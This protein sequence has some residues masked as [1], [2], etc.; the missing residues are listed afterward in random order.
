[1]S[2]DNTVNAVRIGRKESNA[3]ENSSE[4]VIEYIETRI[5]ADL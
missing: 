3:V 5:L 2:C 1:M 4:T